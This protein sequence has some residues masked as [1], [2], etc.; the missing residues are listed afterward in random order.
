M[1]EPSLSHSAKRPVAKRPRP[2]PTPASGHQSHQC[3]FGRTEGISR[4][5]LP[6]VLVRGTSDGA[7]ATGPG[8]WKSRLSVSL[9]VLGALVG[10][11][12]FGALPDQ[13]QP[14]WLAGPDLAGQLATGLGCIQDLRA[15]GYLRPPAARTQSRRDALEPLTAH[16]R[17]TF[18]ATL[19]TY[20]KA[21]EDAEPEF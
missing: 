21:L 19:G 16:E 13:D 12:A 8:G 18:V 11:A 14:T 6:G 4:E 2:A 15:A 5:M 1:A 10:A 7:V 9:C 3:P 20:E 17:R